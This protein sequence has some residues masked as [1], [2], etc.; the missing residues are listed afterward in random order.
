MTKLFKSFSF[1]G[2]YLI[3]SV[4]YFGMTLLLLGILPEIVSFAQSGS[5]S[6]EPE[7]TY[8]YTWTDEDGTTHSETKSG[9]P[10]GSSCC[11][12]SGECVEIE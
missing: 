4:V 2:H 12:E 1:G 3:A 11:S 8:T 5:G 7:C 6:S 9:C 10:S